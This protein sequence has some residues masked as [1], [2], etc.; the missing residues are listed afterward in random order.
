MLELVTLSHTM[1]EKLRIL[2]LDMR[3]LHQWCSA[4]CFLLML[5]SIN[6]LLTT[7]KFQLNLFSSDVLTD[8]EF[9]FF[10]VRFP[11]LRDALEKLQLNDAAL[12]VSPIWKIKFEI[13]TYIFFLNMI[14]IKLQV[15]SNMSVL[16]LT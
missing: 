4:A 16:A 12:K 15:L 9:Y 11:E 5:T 13:G 2:C 8:Y 14:L 6:L 3:K 1:E 7:T 10:F